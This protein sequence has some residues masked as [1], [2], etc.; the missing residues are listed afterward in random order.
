MTE[1]DSGKYRE[2]GNNP[3]N[4]IIWLMWK[5]DWQITASTYTET[6][7]PVRQQ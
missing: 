7:G 1:R 5:Q 3:Q 2:D 4:S 6:M